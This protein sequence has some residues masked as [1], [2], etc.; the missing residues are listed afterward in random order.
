MQQQCII[1]NTSDIYINSAYYYVFYVYRYCRPL[2]ISPFL[3]LS[4][5][6]PSSPSSPTGQIHR[7]LFFL[8]VRKNNVRVLLSPICPTVLSPTGWPTAGDAV[9]II[10]LNIYII[11]RIISSGQ[12]IGETRTCGRALDWFPRDIK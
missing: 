7:F 2:S 11:I 4:E 3:C 8:N 9:V 10:I 1:D 6:F 5:C 12:K